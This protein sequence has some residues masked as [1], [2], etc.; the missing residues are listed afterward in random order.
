MSNMFEMVDHKIDTEL[1]INKVSTPES[2]A[3][4][5]FI[6]IIRNHTG[7]MKVT[8]LFYEAY[9]SM[10]MKLMER[11]GEEVISKFRIEQIAITHRVGKVNVEEASVVIA[12]SAGHREPAFQ[13]CRYAID[14][15]KKIVPIWKKE[16]F[17]NGDQKWIAN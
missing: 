4:S 11:I 1:V 17:E 7:N 13:A 3:I 14:T 5:T 16:F 2:G 6:G 8:H 12:V 10:A 15:L 9:H